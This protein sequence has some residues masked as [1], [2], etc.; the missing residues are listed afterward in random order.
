MYMVLNCYV[1]WLCII[2]LDDYKYEAIIYHTYIIYELM[3]INT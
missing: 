2:N 1:E 3:E